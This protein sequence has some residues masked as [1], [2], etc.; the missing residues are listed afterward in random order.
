MPVKGLV[1]ID[2]SAAAAQLFDNAVIS[3]IL[4]MYNTTTTKEL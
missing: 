3:K 1:N 4:R 2:V